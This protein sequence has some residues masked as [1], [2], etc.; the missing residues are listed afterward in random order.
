ML[1]FK[2]LL[3]GLATISALL[4]SNSPLGNSYTAFLHIPFLSMNW[5]GATYAAN[6]LDLMNDGLMVGFFTLVSLEIKK[7]FIGGALQRWS[8][9]ILPISAA[10]GGVIVPAIFYILFQYYH[11]AFIQGWAIPTAT[12]IAFSLTVLSLFGRSVPSSMRLLLATLAIIDDLCAIGVIAIAYTS[13][14]QWRW[15]GMSF[16]IV[17]GL[18]ALNRRRINRLWPYLLLG[19]CLWIAVLQSGVHATLAGVLVGAIIPHHGGH[20]AKQGSVLC[21]LERYLRPV[22]EYFILPAFAL[23]NASVPLDGFG[24]NVLLH[25]VFLGVFIGLVLGKP[26]GIILGSIL[27]MQTRIVLFPK[28][29]QWGHLFS[30]ACLGGI[31][32]TM[33]L[34]IGSL[35]FPEGPLLSLVRQ[36][37]LAASLGSAIMAW[38]FFPKTRA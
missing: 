28:D 19:F 30:L 35:T 23:L 17:M 37:I 13:Y 3:V 32:F 16:L 11:P 1:S 15:L 31:G 14:L 7:E 38:L 24:W 26:I 22:V 9:A 18:C 27:A 6:V 2:G 33:S 10:L 21:Q 29:M 34:F 36:A 25:P 5:Q 12:D 4:I 20:S 8:Y